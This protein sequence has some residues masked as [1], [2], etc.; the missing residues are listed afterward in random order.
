MIARAGDRA[1]RRMRGGSGLRWEKSHGDGCLLDRCN[2]RQVTVPVLCRGRGR[3]GF[4][5]DWASLVYKRSRVVGQWEERADGSQI[6]NP[7]EAKGNLL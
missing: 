4:R 5:I 3:K 6:V 1:V 2:R 7:L